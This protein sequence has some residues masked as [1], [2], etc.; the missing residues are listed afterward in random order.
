MVLTTAGAPYLE[1]VASGAAFGAGIVAR[2]HMDHRNATAGIGVIGSPEL[3][4]LAW[5]I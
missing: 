3:A 4:G 5:A 1:R 2:R